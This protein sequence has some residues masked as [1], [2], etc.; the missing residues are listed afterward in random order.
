[1]CVAS[2]AAKLCSLLRCM[3]KTRHHRM[4]GVMA[5]ALGHQPIL[6]IA[7]ESPRSLAKVP[8]IGDKRYFG[9]A[10]AVFACDQQA[11]GW[12]G[13]NGA[14]ALVRLPGRSASGS[15]RFLTFAAL[16]PFQDLRALGPN[17]ALA[18]WPAAQLGFRDARER[19]SG[20]GT[21][22]PFRFSRKGSQGWF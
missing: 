10:L 22:N 17:R 9:E 6:R 3:V 16:S 13:A 20:A 7:R 4:L 19:A 8:L 21:K 12:S 18:A 11:V 2:M 15:R 14:A 5:R 1:M